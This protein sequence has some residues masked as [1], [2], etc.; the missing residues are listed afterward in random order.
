[1]YNGFPPSDVQIV[2]FDA[3]AFDVGVT[4][5]RR[6]DVGDWDVTPAVDLA[7][8][9]FGGEIETDYF[10]GDDPLPT[11]LHFGSSVRAASPTTR[12]FGADVPV[13]AMVYSVELIDRMHDADFSWGIGGEIAVAQIVFLR[14]GTSDFEEDTPYD[15]EQDGEFESQSGWGV[16]LGIP[17]GAARTRFDYTKISE[18][19]TEKKLGVSLEWIF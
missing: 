15:D 18:S 1:V 13:L 2:D 19:Y 16:G 4:L 14:A 8:V 17:I 3:L 5:A 7:Y 10:D 11:R 9:N 6:Y 12:V